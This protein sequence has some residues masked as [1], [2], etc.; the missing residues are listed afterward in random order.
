LFTH[1]FPNAFPHK[2]TNKESDNTKS[3]DNAYAFTYRTHT[4]I[5]PN[6]FPIRIANP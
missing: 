4:N 1:K 2:F 3:D 6:A 5:T